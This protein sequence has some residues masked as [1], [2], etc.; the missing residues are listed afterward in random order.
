MKGQVL[1]TDSKVELI[2]ERWDYLLSKWINIALV[3]KDEGMTRLLFEIRKIKPNVKYYLLKNYIMQCKV[4]H[5]MAFL[6]WRLHFC[7]GRKEST[8]SCQM[9]IDEI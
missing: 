2:S 7:S 6:Q 8:S 3:S 9:D 4:F 5:A 1:A